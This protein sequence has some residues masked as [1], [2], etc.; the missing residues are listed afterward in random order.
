MTLF[1]KIASEKWRNNRVAFLDKGFN[2]MNN[3]KKITP[4]I[5]N[6]IALITLL[7][8]TLSITGCAAT[9]PTVSPTWG[10][11]GHI[12]PPTIQA[13]V[14]E[15]HLDQTTRIEFLNPVSHE[16][17]VTTTQSMIQAIVELLDSTMDNC[18]ET[19]ESTNYALLIQMLVPAE[20]GE[21]A[22]S[23]D[24]HPVTSVVLLDNIPTGSWPVKIQ[25][26]YSVCPGFG[27]SLFGLLG[28]NASSVEPTRF[29]A[30]IFGKLVDEEGCLR[31]IE[32]TTSTNYL[33]AWPPVFSVCTEQNRNISSYT[34]PKTQ[35]P[36]TIERWNHGYLF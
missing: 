12:N 22:I 21:H 30:L 25:G 4:E 3:Q 2:P 7:T 26:S 32:R 29:A 31:I 5:V 9:L 28:I 15:V 27:K 20:G 33:I 36:D 17:V 6:R 10:L 8:L 14:D 13:Y 19:P 11:Q 35:K 16:Q 24:Y 18:A 1:L 34:L 23:V